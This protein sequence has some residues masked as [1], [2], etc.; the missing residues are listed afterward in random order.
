[1]F[2]PFKDSPKDRGLFVNT[3]EQ[4]YS[5]VSAA[6]KAGLHVMVHAIGDRAINTLNIYTRRQGERRAR[7][8]LSDRVRSAPGAPGHSSLRAAERDRE[9][10]AVSRNRRR[11]LGGALHRRSN[12]NDV[13]V[14]GFDRSTGP[15]HVRERLVRRASNPARGNLRSRHA[16]NAGRKESRWVGARTEDHDGRSTARLHFRRCT[17]RVRG[18]CKGHSC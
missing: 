10:A 2:E 9:H 6:D 14:S 5:W 1:M 8:A 12:R 13:C 15:P 7:S 3:P 4:L 17:C 11:T 16:A 18:A